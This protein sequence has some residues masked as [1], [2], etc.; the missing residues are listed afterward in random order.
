MYIASF[1]IELSRETLARICT[2]ARMHTICCMI[3]DAGASHEC[4]FKLKFYYE[5]LF[6]LCVNNSKLLAPHVLDSYIRYILCNS[7]CAYGI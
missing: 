2:F 6:C 3:N 5:V 1:L 4:T 7:Y